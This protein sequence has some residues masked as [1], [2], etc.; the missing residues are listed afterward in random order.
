VTC[1]SMSGHRRWSGHGE[2]HELV[3]PVTTPLSGRRASSPKLAT[4]ADA[5]YKLPP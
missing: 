4:T 5:T 1:F 3:A 2:S